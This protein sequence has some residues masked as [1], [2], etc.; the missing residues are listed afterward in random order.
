MSLTQ[1][2]DLLKEIL[3]FIQTNMTM[4]EILGLAT[5]FPSLISNGMELERFPRDEDMIDRNIKGIY[6]LD[7]DKEVVKQQ[8]Q[9]YIFEDK[10]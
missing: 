10:K 3:P 6:Y 9:D 2:P 1:Y 4:S 5:E 8:I 7:F